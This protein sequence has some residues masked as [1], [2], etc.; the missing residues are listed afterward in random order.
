MVEHEKVCGFISAGAK[1]IQGKAGNM[2]IETFFSATGNGK[3]LIKITA[4]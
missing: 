3:S 2:A 1:R 4:K